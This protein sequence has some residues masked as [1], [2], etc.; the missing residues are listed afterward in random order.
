MGCQSGIF[1]TPFM[2]KSQKTSKNVIVSVIK[3]F[4]GGK[5]QIDGMAAFITH[6]VIVP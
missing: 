4:M 2:Y 6:T 1:L 5:Q 3:Y